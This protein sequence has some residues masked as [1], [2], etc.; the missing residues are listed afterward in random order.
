MMWQEK[1]SGAGGC[2]RLGAW[3][4]DLCLFSSFL[5]RNFT[6]VLEL[7]SWWKLHCCAEQPAGAKLAWS[8]CPF[9]LQF[10]LLRFV[11][12]GFGS[13]C[14]SQLPDLEAAL[15]PLL[16]FSLPGVVKLKIK[17]FKSGSRLNN[18][19]QAIVSGALQ[20]TQSAFN[21]TSSCNST[22]FS[23]NSVF[24]LGRNL[25]LNNKHPDIFFF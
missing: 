23:W 18:L 6:W 19:G 21:L 11:T 1:G 22:K 14:S 8:S 3:R 4:A 24:P 16:C 10:F 20:E 12:L 15:K 25:K 5:G 9:P 17:W 13:W 2:P 7:K